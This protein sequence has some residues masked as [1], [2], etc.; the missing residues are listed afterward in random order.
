MQTGQ[1]ILR[2][3]Y[4]PDLLP[5]LLRHD[6]RAVSEAEAPKL[7]VLPMEAAR[8]QPEPTLD[9][10]MERIESYL[11]AATRPRSLR[12]GGS[13][14]DAAAKRARYY[15]ASARVCLRSC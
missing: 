10:V 7:A 5:H 4:P 8:Q 1:D 14:A 12:P 13:L 2:T 15:R 11:A 3:G 9:A 6:W